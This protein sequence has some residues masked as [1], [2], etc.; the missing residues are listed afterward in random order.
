LLKLFTASKQKRYLTRHFLI[1]FMVSPACPISVHKVKQPNES[2]ATE[3]I[4]TFLYMSDR[5][6]TAFHRWPNLKVELKKRILAYLL[7]AEITHPNIPE[8]NWR[9]GPVISNNNVLPFLEN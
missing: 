4:E 5:P 9:T 7:D 6:P 2:M 8:V 3:E 1:Y